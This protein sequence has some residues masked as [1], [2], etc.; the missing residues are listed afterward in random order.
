MLEACFLAEYLLILGSGTKGPLHVKVCHLLIPHVTYGESQTVSVTLLG[1]N[2]F[3][4]SNAWTSKIVLSDLIV[5]VN[6][7]YA[8]CR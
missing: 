5:L 7:F 8:I 6:T 2:M 3:F 1:R 4:P